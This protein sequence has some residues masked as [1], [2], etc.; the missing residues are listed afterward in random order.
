MKYEKFIEALL[1]VVNV[2]KEV[3]WKQR[4]ILA[5]G[6]FGET[7]DDK[8]KQYREELQ[9]YFFEKGGYEFHEYWTGKKYL[10]Q[11]SDSVSLEPDE[12]E[13][14]ID[15]IY[16]MKGKNFSRIKPL[17]ER[18]KELEKIVFLENDDIKSAALA[19][20]AV[21]KYHAGPLERRNKSVAS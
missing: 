5:E 20:K 13:S 16:D 8:E 17:C 15:K 6:V 3:S 9:Q 1:D 10:A 14:D 21:S 18:L 4:W 2:K 19:G 11:L 12:E 7:V